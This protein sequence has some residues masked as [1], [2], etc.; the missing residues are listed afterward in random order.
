M[1]LFLFSG[2]MSVCTK[3]CQEETEKL[4]ELINVFNWI[5]VQIIKNNF[6]SIFEQ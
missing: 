3:N 4:L 1:Q 6:M 5:Q 2:N